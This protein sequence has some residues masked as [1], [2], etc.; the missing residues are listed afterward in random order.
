MPSSARYCT[1]RSPSRTADTDSNWGAASGI[2]V[3]LPEGPTSRSSW[4]LC[5]YLPG[6]LHDILVGGQLPQAHWPPGVQL[7]GADADLGAEAE[8]LTV[9]ETGRGVDHH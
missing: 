3:S 2:P 1:E 5:T 8:L 9:G 4:A 6:S 7:L